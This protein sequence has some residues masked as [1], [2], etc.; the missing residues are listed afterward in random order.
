VIS[1]H[2]RPSAVADVVEVSEEDGA[3]LKNIRGREDVPS[4]LAQV[5][6]ETEIGQAHP[7]DPR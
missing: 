6:W 7:P 2:L 1:V 5:R 3:G 4:R